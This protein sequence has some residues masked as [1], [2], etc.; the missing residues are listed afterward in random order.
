MIFSD[1]RVVIEAQYFPS[2]PYY[3]LLHQV[4][5]SVIDIHEHFVKQTYRNRTVINGANGPLTLTIPIKHASPKMVLKNVKVE[6]REKWINQHWR[7]IQSAYGKAPFFDY[8]AP[9]IEPIFIQEKTYL[10]EYLQESLS[11]C[12]KLL[13]LELEVT[14]S[15]KYIE[16]SAEADLDMRSVITPKSDLGILSGFSPQAYFQLFGKDFVPNL[17]VLDLLFCEG[18]NAAAIIKGSGQIKKEQLQKTGRSVL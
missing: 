18:P 16:S 10:L 9:Y 3:W 7:S 4:D 12:Q 2:I 5:Q 17:S 1:M 13:G 6:H 11:I 8:Y 15:E 14:N